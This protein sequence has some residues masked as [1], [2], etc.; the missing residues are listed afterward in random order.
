[1]SDFKAVLALNL[2]HFCL[3]MIKLAKRPN[4][5]TVN[6]KN[7]VVGWKSHTFLRKTTCWYLYWE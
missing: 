6:I 5:N 7:N 3:I 1:M 4:Q 2:K